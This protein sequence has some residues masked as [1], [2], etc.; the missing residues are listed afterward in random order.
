MNN[1]TE[2]Q[3]SL[4]IKPGK[5][6]RGGGIYEQ[7]TPSGSR[8]WILRV[9]KD[10]RRREF[11]V[12]SC[13]TTTLTQARANAK[14]VRAQL[15]AGLDPVA[16]RRK[17]AETPT[18]AEAAIIVHTNETAD[19]KAGKHVKQWLSLIENYANPVIG[20]IR[21]DRV[22]ERDVGTLLEPIWLDKP[23][24]AKKVRRNVLTVLDWAYGLDYRPAPINL[25]K[26]KAV[27]A[28]RSK[29]K[30]K[31]NHHAA[32]GYK[33]VPA[34]MI[35]LSKRTGAG[36]L[37]LQFAILTAARSGEVRGAT[38]DEFDL[39]ERTWT[40]PEERMKAGRQHVVPLS[41]G[42]MAVL[43]DAQVVRLQGR[44]HVFLTSTVDK[45]MSDMTMTAVLKR[46]GLKGKA[47][48]HGFRSSFR[49][50][51]SATYPSEREAAE[52][53]LA[54]GVSNAVE[55][56]YLRDTL[57][58]RRV[59]LMEDWSGFCLGETPV[60]GESHNVTEIRHG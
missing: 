49:N 57:F 38:W 56:A 30:T 48:A 35:E 32:L 17:L 9:Q 16:E 28:K 59:R 8:S 25:S 34:F 42:A 40:I 23:A 1:E 11:G 10:R 12:G 18:F 26:L 21:I 52:F 33:E 47:T 36:V 29:Q 43:R 58:D 5:F 14:G 41:D 20:K 51:S 50:W 55:A 60:T 13:Q 31:T 3:E 53:S 2:K 19:A 39:V 44:S 54:H 24:T 6:A 7:V 15:E 45:P 22:T 4:R 37:A 27:L 46:M